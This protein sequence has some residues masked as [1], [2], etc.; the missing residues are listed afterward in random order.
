MNKFQ[1]IILLILLIFVYYKYY[2]DNSIKKHLFWSKQ[3][4]TINKQLINDTN[5]YYNKLPKH[6]SFITFD[7]N[8]IDMF[9]QF[10]SKN[11]I[12]N[13]KY[14][15][16][17][18]QWVINTNYLFKLSK[19]NKFNIGLFNNKTN[20]LIGTII[21]IPNII[22]IDNKIFKVLYVDFLCVHK[23]ERNKLLAPLLISKI[24][25]QSEKYKF[26][27]NIFKIDHTP[28]PF[29]Y[30]YKYNYYY[31]KIPIKKYINN[32]QDVD[33]YNLLS[34]PL[35]KDYEIIFKYFMKNI[36]KHN[37]MQYF[38]FDE[39]KY[40]FLND[41]N[42]IGTYIV[43][44]EKHTKDKKRK[45]TSKIKGFISFINKKCIIKNKEENIIELNYMFNDCDICIFEMIENIFYICSQDKK[46][47]KNY[48]K[49][50]ICKDIL[51]YKEI[52][53]QYNFNY[54]YS[55]HYHV[56]N[57][58]NVNELNIINNYDNCYLKY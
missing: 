9:H 16:E 27:F 39:F 56:H 22:K 3:C 30:I 53:F 15:L 29:D 19:Y 34:T 33:N 37:M 5:Y 14:T 2:K 52:I 21:G 20:K 11:Y 26:D 12:K 50:I 35:E 31:Y 10:I 49:Y 24:I 58:K 40:Y 55:T 42:F 51:N 45:N 32:V 18:L 13:D 28:L 4:V 47:N 25:K 36:N 46:N 1:T 43:K 8:N 7:N 17:Y 41:N 23:K 6:L 57:C 54:I 38:S 48:A 44:Q